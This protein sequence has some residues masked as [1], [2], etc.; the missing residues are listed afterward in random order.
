MILNTALADLRKE[1][2]EMKGMNI[3]YHGSAA[4]VMLSKR[5]ARQTGANINVFKGHALDPVHNL[6]GMNTLN[7]LRMAGSLIAS[8]LIFQGDRDLSPHSKAEG[9]AQRLSPVFQ[10]AIFHP[11]A[12]SH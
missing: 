11:I 8:P 6:V 7:P 4:N 2:K 10:S 1:G 5:L 3:T 9:Q 12:P